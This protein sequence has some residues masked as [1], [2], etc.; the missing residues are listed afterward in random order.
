MYLRAFS[1][2]HSA[3]FSFENAEIRRKYEITERVTK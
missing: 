3:Y 1:D 2:L